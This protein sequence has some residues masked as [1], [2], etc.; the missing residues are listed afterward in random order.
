[1]SAASAP[2]HRTPFDHHAF[3][4]MAAN[5]DWHPAL[6]HMHRL[7]LQIEDPAQQLHGIAAMCAFLQQNWMVM[8]AMDDIRAAAKVA[9]ESTSAWAAAPPIVAAQARMVLWIIQQIEAM[10]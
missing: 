10:Q 3:K 1:M 4:A 5:V 6:E 9:M 8:I 7:L 2:D